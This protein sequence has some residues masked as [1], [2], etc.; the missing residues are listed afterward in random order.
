MPVFVA[1]L[2]SILGILRR[3]H[4]PPLPHDARASQNERSTAF[5]VDAAS[6]CTI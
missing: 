5:T 6:I 4:Q 3:R 1:R 2:S